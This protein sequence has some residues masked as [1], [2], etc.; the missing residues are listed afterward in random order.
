MPE[1]SL[2]TKPSPPYASFRT[3]LNLFEKMEIA[4]PPRIDRSYLSGS[5]GGKTQLLAALKFFSLINSLGE[6]TPALVTIVN[7][8]KDRPRLIKELLQSHYPEAI[9]LSGINATQRQLEESFQ[10]LGGDTA[11]KAIT[12]FLHAAKFA[13]LPVSKNFKVPH[14]MEGARRNGTRRKPAVQ[15]AKAPVEHP[16]TPAADL[17]TRY[18]ELLMEKAA[19]DDKL[20]ADL[21][22]RI[23]KLLDVPPGANDE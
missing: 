14:G 1:S 16:R 13:Q 9:R 6:V 8:P 22:D 17:R 12:F 4:I 5:E 19:A 11:R 2:E 7:S 15:T 23:E 21:L 18:I 20:D 3:L 10:P